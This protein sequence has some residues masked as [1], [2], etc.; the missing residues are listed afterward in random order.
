[1]KVLSFFLKNILAL[2]PFRIARIPYALTYHFALWGIGISRSSLWPR[3]SY[4]FERIVMFVSDLDLTLLLNKGSSLNTQTKRKI[5]RTQK[6][7]PLL[8][9]LNIVHEEMI[10]KYASLLPILELK[11]DPILLRT[12]QLSL[13]EAE[14]GEKFFFLWRMLWSDRKNL[15]VHLQM[16]KKKWTFHLESLQLGTDSFL[17]AANLGAFLES[18]DSQ[19]ECSMGYLQQ[20]ALQDEKSISFLRDELKLVFFLSD[21]LGEIYQKRK[22]EKEESWPVLGPKLHHMLKFSLSWEV[23]GVLS[24]FELQTNLTEFY[25]HVIGLKKISLHYS[26]DCFLPALLEVE[27]LVLERMALSST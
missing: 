15:R 12:L 13:R 18:L 25:T 26:Y 17:T 22:W 23:W 14:E 1:M 9:E 21:W 4:Y 19:F 6:L 5:M 10:P 3:N 27:G 7:L 24:Q 16:R 2:I 8:G 20:L 11:R